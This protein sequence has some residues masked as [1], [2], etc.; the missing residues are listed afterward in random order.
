MAGVP[1]G[2]ILGPLLFLIFINDIENDIKSDISLYADD[3]CLINIYQNPKTAET[4]LNNDLLKIETWASK[5]L[6]EFN[7]SKTI[8][9]NFSL[10]VNKSRL[11]LKFK[12]EKILQVT[13]HKHLGI[14]FSEDMKWLKHISYVTAKASKRIGQLY[15]CSIHLRKNQLNNVYIK[16]IRPILEYGSVVFCN[17]S[18]VASKKLDNIQRRAGLICT[19]AMRRTE[20]SKITNLLAWPSLEERRTEQRFVMFFKILNNL[21]PV[22]SVLKSEM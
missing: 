5:W 8:F 14:I 3:T 16:M 22:I 12:S 17:C 13:E 2:S 18:V 9:V 11:K 7:Q 19:G 10:K 1:E 4:C 6:V 15:R 21:A 20:T